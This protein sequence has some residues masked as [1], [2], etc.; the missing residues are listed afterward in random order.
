MKPKKFQ[1]SEHFKQKNY[2][3]KAQDEESISPIERY[4]LTGSI[5]Y[6]FVTHILL[7]VLGACQVIL[8]ISKITDYSRNQQR[9]FYKNFLNDADQEGNDYDKK[10]YIY[11]I[12]E[13]KNFITTSIDNY[14][15]LEKNS[16]EIIEY[17]KNYIL[18][19]FD[20]IS[21]NYKQK[22]E[23]DK[24]I[25]Q[26]FNLT[27]KEWKD[28]Y[29]HSS[30][31]YNSLTQK[32]IYKISK[33]DLGPFNED[34][35][36]IR[37]LLSDVI[38]F[39]IKYKIKTYIPYFYE[40]SHECFDWNIEQIFTF[41]KRAHITAKLYSN[42][43]PCKDTLN[44]P[45][46]TEFVDQHHWIN[47][48]VIFLSL[49]SFINAIRYF[50]KLASNYITSK[51]KINKK[52]DELDISY[53][54]SE[55]SDYYNPLFT[56]T[57]ENELQND[58]LDKFEEKNN[59]VYSD[60]EIGNINSNKSY[61]STCIR[62]DN[63]N[64][65]QLLK[66]ASS[67]NNIINNAK[68]DEYFLSKD[69]MKG[70]Q[71]CIIRNTDSINNNKLIKNNVKDSFSNIDDNLNNNI[72]NNDILDSSKVSNSPA[73]K[74]LLKQ[75]SSKTKTKV[76]FHEVSN[77]LK[78]QETITYQKQNSSSINKDGEELLNS[79]KLKEIAQYKQLSIS[80][81][82]DNINFNNNIN[83][84]KTNKE[85]KLERLDYFLN[86]NNNFYSNTKYNNDNIHSNNNNNNNIFSDYNNS[87]SN[88]PNNVNNQNITQ[89]DIEHSKFQ[90][91]LNIGWTFISIL[92]SLLQFF[93]SIMIFINASKMQAH[94]EFLIGLGCMFAFFNI[95]RYLVY[96]K[97]YYQIYNTV[98]LTMPIV[99]R[100]LIGV[101][102]IFIGFIL[103]G[104]C[105]FWRSDNFSSPSS[106]FMTL[107]SVSQGDVIY[108]I[109]SDL[110][111]INLM[112]GYLYC[113]SFI[114]FFM[115]VVMNIFIAIIEE[116]YVEVKMKN[117]DHWIFNYMN[118]TKSSLMKRI[119]NN[120]SENNDINEDSNISDV[121]EEE[122]NIKRMNELNNVSNYILNYI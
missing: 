91:D 66:N 56:M 81:I 80:N 83:E 97:Q 114:I 117:E 115:T 63:I 70:S 100:Y 2:L 22:E 6:I 42:K 31:N 71:R 73:H 59:F 20:Y 50:S 122:K 112:L 68:Q 9:V 101:S 43:K 95:G 44:T 107:F 32:Y 84:N 65:S 60:N 33:K 116:S 34:K 5:P 53:S 23:I 38:R 46:L 61:A 104:C 7:A 90:R 19:E 15:N 18:L 121:I 51:Q 17:D 41:D 74:V 55:E 36:K 106:V 93:G 24:D 11:S 16:L 102:P 37:L 28:L 94:V 25:L 82:E 29:Y 1:F 40:N 111:S 96:S 21:L 30:D 58:Y 49:F 120:E 89:Q 12:S 35:D 113:Y 98:S 48:L 75:L 27:K 72:V 69:S 47:I 108:D 13:L 118:K 52:L 78:K 62:K 57:T 105:L 119:N 8:I 76:S 103:L 3:L 67:S 87:N 77:Y 54:K 10:H 39:R 26:S 4:K 109:F 64:S 88:L 86:D 14:Y 85:D 110:G 99:M 92:S 79:S 45:F